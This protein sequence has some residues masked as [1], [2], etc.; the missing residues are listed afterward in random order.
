MLGKKDLELSE[1][2]GINDE[3]EMIELDED[4]TE[5]HSL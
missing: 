5:N 3:E 4:E 1:F 2:R